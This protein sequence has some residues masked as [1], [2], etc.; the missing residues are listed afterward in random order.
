MRRHCLCDSNCISTVLCC[1]CAH[2][3]LPACTPAAARRACCSDCVH[4]VHSTAVSVFEASQWRGSHGKLDAGHNYE[5][6]F[7]NSLYTVY[8]CFKNNVSVTDPRGKTGGGSFQLHIHVSNDVMKMFT[9]LLL[10]AM[11]MSGYI[12]TQ[13]AFGTVVSLCLLA[14]GG[15]LWLR[16]GRAAASACSG[17]CFVSLASNHPNKCDAGV[18]IV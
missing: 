1:V 6:C 17:V 5:F 9:S 16:L 2:A 7:A 13:A 4:Y 12:A 3:A 18:F 14:T 11:L 10:Q 15:S 8:N